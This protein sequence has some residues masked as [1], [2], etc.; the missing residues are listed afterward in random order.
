MDI[1]DEYRGINLDNHMSEAYKNALYD[2]VSDHYE[3][4]MPPS[5][6][7]AV[8]GRGTDLA[9]RVEL[10]FIDYCKLHGLSHFILWVDLSKAFDRVIREL[11]LGIPHDAEWF[12]QQGGAP[13]K[14]IRLLKNLHAKS[15]ITHGDIDSAVSIRLGGKQCCKFGGAA[16]NGVYSVGLVMLRDELLDVSVI[17]VTF[18]DDECLMLSAPAPRVQDERVDVLLTKLTSSIFDM[19]NFSMNWKPGNT[20]CSI[21]YRGARSAEHYRRRR[22]SPGQSLAVQVPGRD[23]SITVVS[24]CKHLGGV[25][26]GTGQ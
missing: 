9:I 19:L 17:D 16:F 18:V 4:H 24:E 6:Y 7:G 2:E 21:V 22:R 5:Q 15:W 1:C 26:S 13:E 3:Q 25:A 12:L 14:T 10:S 20:K 23:E 11:V 8:S